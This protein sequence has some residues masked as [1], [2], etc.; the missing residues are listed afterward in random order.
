MYAKYKGKYWFHPKNLDYFFAQN[1][2]ITDK[3]SLNVKKAIKKI[4]S[5]TCRRGQKFVPR[6]QP[7][8]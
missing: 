3:K 1:M 6:L 5:I 8:P 4:P 2:F 7:K